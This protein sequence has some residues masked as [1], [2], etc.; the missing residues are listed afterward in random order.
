MQY[1]MWS[2]VQPIKTESNVLAGVEE[3]NNSILS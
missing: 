2:I 1:I 3:V